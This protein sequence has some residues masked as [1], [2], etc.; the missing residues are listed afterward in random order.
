MCMH[1]DRMHHS[2]VQLATV[3]QLGEVQQVQVIGAARLPSLATSVLLHYLPWLTRSKE[4]P[5]W[6]WLAR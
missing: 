6:L 1:I 5:A 2:T 4:P 3:I